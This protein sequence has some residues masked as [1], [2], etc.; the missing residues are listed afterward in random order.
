VSPGSQ[1]VNAGDSAFYDVSSSALNG[2][3]G[4][5]ALSAGGPGGDIF[6]DLSPSTIGANGSSTLTVTTSSTTAAGTY[7]IT[8]NGSSG[9]LSRSASV[10]I[11]VNSSCL[12]RGICP[13]Q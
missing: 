11:T 5:V 6:V 2:F 4:A 9:T 10:S 1:T 8:I 3:T 13:L 7:F 12:D